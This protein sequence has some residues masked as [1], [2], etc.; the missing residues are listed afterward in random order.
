MIAISSILFLNYFFM[1]LKQFVTFEYLL[2]AKN[3]IHIFKIL[4]QSN[5]SNI[6]NLPR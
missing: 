4:S 5:L 3:Y 1:Y 6:Y 2:Y